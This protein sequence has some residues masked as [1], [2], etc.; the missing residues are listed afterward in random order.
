MTEEDL[1]TILAASRPVP[2]LVIG[3]VAPP[4]PQTNANIAWRALAAR[5]GFLW[6][7]VRPVHGEPQTVFTAVPSV[8]EVDVPVDEVETVVDGG[9]PAGLYVRLDGPPGPEPGAFVELEDE[10]G[11]S[12][13]PESGATWHRDGDH[14]LLGPFVRVDPP[15]AS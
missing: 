14:W 7:S 5:M 1:Q 6:D 8:V 9:L 13:G 10:Q 12:Y 2:Y 4:S 11:R 15:V 3:G